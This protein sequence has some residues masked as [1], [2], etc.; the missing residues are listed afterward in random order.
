MKITALFIALTV[1]I[2]SA[3]GKKTYKKKKGETKKVETNKSST[4]A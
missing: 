2:S 3:E 4:K 1:F